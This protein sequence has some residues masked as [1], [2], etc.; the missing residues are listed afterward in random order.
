MTTMNIKL[1]PSLH[2]GFVKLAR[3]EKIPV[4]QLAALALAEKMSALMTDEYF[5]RRR[6]SGDRKTYLKVLAKAPDVA[7]D[8]T[9]RLP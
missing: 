4:G 1:P 3:K 5:S 7:P 6:R 9:D 8:E 2:K